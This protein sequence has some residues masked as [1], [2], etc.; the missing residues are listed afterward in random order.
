MSCLLM[1]AVKPFIHEVMRVLAPSCGDLASL[2]K[3][4]EL[5]SELHEHLLLL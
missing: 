4:E 1:Y 5:C 2:C 3:T